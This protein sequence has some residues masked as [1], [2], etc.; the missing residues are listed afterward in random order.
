[1]G[2]LQRNVVLT[3]FMGTGKTT[4]G[5]LLAERLRYEFVDTDVVIIERHGPIPQIFAEHGEARFRELEREVVGELAARDGLVISTGGGL[6]ADTANAD[7]LGATG[8][9]FTLVASVDTIF[10]RV[11]GDDAATKRPLLAASDARER[12]T[13][14][15]AQRASAYGR[16]IQVDTDGR[17]PDEVADEIAS[18]VE[19]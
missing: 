19:R 8:E 2:E 11:G 7:V 1:M 14:L 18:T 4:V 13:D 5:Q 12:V 6:M 16:F 3:G 17:S 15:L 9:V 10:E